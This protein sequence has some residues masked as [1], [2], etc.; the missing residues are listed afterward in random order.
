VSSRNEA[1]DGTSR[2]DTELD[3]RTR[4]LVE[5][6]VAQAGLELVELDIRGRTGSRIVRV[7]VDA[8]PGVD[9]DTCAQVSR[10]LSG[11]FDDDDV[12]PGRYTLEVTSPGVDRPLRTARD[13]ERNVGRSVRIWRTAAAIEAGAKGETDGEL[14]EV[15]G[16]TITL[17]LGDDRQVVPLDQVE[18]GKVLLPW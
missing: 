8:E 14:V 12:I 2:A 1:S 10:T 16:D 17:D 11:A 7:I 13:F 18:R 15:A 4:A 3:Q 9:L 6:L 5:P